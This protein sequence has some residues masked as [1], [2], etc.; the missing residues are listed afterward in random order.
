MINVYYLVFEKES[1]KV[2]GKTSNERKALSYVEKSNGIY[3]YQS[4]EEDSQ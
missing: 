2:I 3:D 1:G 4:Y